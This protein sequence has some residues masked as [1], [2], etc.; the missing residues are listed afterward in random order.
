VR[1]SVDTFHEDRIGLEPVV[2]WIEKIEQ[3]APDWSIAI[4]GLRVI[5]DDSIERLAARLGGELRPIRDWYAWMILPSG[6]KL[7]VERK[8]FVVEG[9]GRLRVLQRRGLQ[10]TSSDREA[11]LGI[12]S[13]ADDFQ[14]LGRPLSV[15]L[16]V[17]HQRLDLEIHSDAVVHILESQ[18][19]DLRMSLLETPWTDVKGH[20]YRDPILHRVVEAGLPGVALLLSEAR[21]LKVAS[22]DVVPYSIEKLVNP[23][24][25]AWVTAAAIETNSDKFVYTESVCALARKHLRLISSYSFDS[26]PVT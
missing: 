26:N 2:E 3:T 22:D 25:L 4:R 21:R 23:A 19:T 8:G 24:A 18:A 11:L 14:E 15:R 16:T 9:R 20:Y 10:L 7:L 6:R 17:T 1:L 13:E 5:G 12:A